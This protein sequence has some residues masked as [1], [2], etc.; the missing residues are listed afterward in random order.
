MEKM[1]RINI[2][3][4]IIA[5][6]FFAGCDDY[7]DK[8]PFDKLANNVIIDN[9]DYAT[10]YLYQA[11]N[12]LPMGYGDRET[13]GHES[14]GNGWFFNFSTL[15]DEM[16]NKSG[17]IQSEKVYI[18]GLLNTKNNQIDAWEKRYKAIRIC[19][20]LVSAMDEATFGDEADR[21]LISAE[22]R[23]VRAFQYFDLTKKYGNVPLIKIAQGLNDEDL[24]VSQTSQSEIFDFIY[25]ELNSIIDILPAHADNTAAH[26]GRAT[27]EAAWALNG[28]V[29]LFAGRY[30]QAAELNE[31]IIDA[32]VFSLAPDYG[33]Y[34]ESDGG[35]QSSPETI[36]E[37]MFQDPLKVH[38]YG[39]DAA[40]VR[41]GGGSQYNP[42][43][44][45]V[46]EYEMANGLAIT[47]PLSGY[48]EQ[49]PYIGRDKRFYESVLYHGAPYKGDVMDMSFTY[50]AEKDKYDPTGGDAVLKTGLHTA[51]GYYLRK[52]THESTPVEPRPNTNSWKTFRYGEI[53]LNYAEAKNEVDGAVAE[54]YA[55]INEVRDRAEMPAI[56]ADL[57]KDEMRTVIRH[58]RHI[59][60]AYEG[61]RY[62]DLIR[63]KKSEEVLNNKKF[64]GMKV[65]VDKDSGNLRYERFV[66]RNK[67]QVFL[68]KHYLWPIPQDEMDKNPNLIQNEGY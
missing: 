23:F 41:F 7:L 30:A 18:P 28:R 50:N 40:P 60:L 55:A 20:N 48:D 11:Y 3:I 59:E 14:S 36:F 1:R 53:L 6:V 33:A 9:E 22:A 35:Y 62:W 52:F 49:N 24:L 2:Y 31:N 15:C 42:V 4:A 5:T 43:Q 54:V 64:T 39:A 25:S 58:E 47:D 19:N 67:M 26:Y 68:P 38:T 45:I 57:S 27:K 13:V 8:E 37:I 34:F 12:F 44:E 29:M 21:A 10:S 66:M 61:Q 16:R 17:W 65:Y 32:G 46:D 63:W 51:S 56:A